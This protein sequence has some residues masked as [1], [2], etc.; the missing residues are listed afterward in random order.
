MRDRIFGSKKA[1]TSTFS[2]PSLVSATTP[3]ANR[4]RGFDIAN[5]API[6]ASSEVSTD[7]QAAQS[8]GEQSWESQA[9]KK[10]PVHNNRFSMDCT[11]SLSQLLIIYFDLFTEPSTKSKIFTSLPIYDW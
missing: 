1:D 7:L 9:I 10:K 6:Q 5:K 4:V 2:N 11:K 3:M 8:A